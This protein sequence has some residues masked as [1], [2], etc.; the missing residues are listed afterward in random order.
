MSLRIDDL[1]IAIPGK[2]SLRV[3][4]EVKAG[5]CVHLRGPSGCGKTTLLKTLC[6]LRDPLAGRVRLGESDIQALPLSRNGMGLVFQ[7]GALFPHLSVMENVVF[8]LRERRGEWDDSLLFAKGREALARAGL[9]GFGERSVAGLSGGER[10]RI[11]LLRTL[12]C[13]PKALLLDEPFSA[14]DE[15]RRREL[16]KWMRELLADVPVPVI[17]TGHDEKTPEL[18]ARSRR[19]EWNETCLEF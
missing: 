12:L 15:E 14:L 19:V 6:G 3:R 13:E 4:G 18:G 17:V 9:D 5:E 8:G 7:S 1:V 10:S 16:E 2:T 11:S